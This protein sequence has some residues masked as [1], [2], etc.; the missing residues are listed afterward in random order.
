MCATRFC[1]RMQAH[2]EALVLIPT[3]VPPSAALGEH[4]SWRFYLHQLLGALSL[5]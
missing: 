4:K 2:A 3:R 1:A 5:W